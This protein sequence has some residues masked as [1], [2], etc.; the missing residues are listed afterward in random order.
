MRQSIVRSDFSSTC[1]RS[2]TAFSKSMLACRAE[3][4]RDV[5]MMTAIMRPMLQRNAFKHFQQVDCISLVRR[6]ATL[7]QMLYCIR[8]TLGILARQAQRHR[9][10]RECLCTVWFLG[11]RA[12]SRAQVLWKL[13][14]FVRYEL[15]R[16]HE[17]AHTSHDAICREHSLKEVDL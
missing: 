7:Q 15:G 9:C 1:S 10:G 14:E 8:R 17:P 6:V 3:L 16:A 2:S 13:W 5:Q 4:E 12:F 11:Q